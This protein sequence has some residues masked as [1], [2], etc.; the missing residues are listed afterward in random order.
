MLSKDR[1]LNSS[2]E[3]LKRA[4]LVGTLFAVASFVF[5]ILI[6]LAVFQYNHT[7]NLEDLRE[8]QFKELNLIK[9]EIQ[10]YYKY[11]LNSINVYS[12]IDATK[13]YLTQPTPKLESWLQNA[14]MQ[15]SETAEL[16]Q[17]MRVIDQHGME[18]IRVDNH[19][20]EGVRLI[21]HDELQDKSS[22]YYVK[23]TIENDTYQIY[24][25][26]FDLNI[27]NG[28]ID[29]PY[30][31]VIRLGNKI[32]DDNGSIL[33]VIIYNISGD[34]LFEV[35][36]G[37]KIHEKDNIYLLNADGY[38]LYHSDVDKTFTF[39]FEDRK[40]EGFFS[41]YPHI[42]E[43]IKSGKNES[44]SNEER[45][46]VLQMELFTKYTVNPKNNT[47]YLVMDTPNSLIDLIDK[48]LKFS[49]LF[50]TALLGPVFLI[51][52]WL[53]GYNLTKNKYYKDT[54]LDIASKDKLTGLYNRR[55]IYDRLEDII[56][57]SKRLNHQVTIVFVD[58]DRLK[59]V[60][61]NLG[62]DMGDAMIQSAADALTSSIR[63]AD[64]AARLGGDEFLLIL[65]DCDADNVK[66]II[67]RAAKH[68]EDKGKELADMDWS[69]SYG[70]A[71]Y[72]KEDT[73]DSLINR[74][75]A[76]MYKHKSS[77]R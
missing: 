14:M 50:S 12:K 35:I 13:N 18:R 25:S 52:S 7:H 32:L 49:L 65:I 43:D 19:L 47:Y 61:D 9:G 53:L 41:D 37:Q 77:R 56:E 70:L 17:Q 60:N 73:L 44:A 2:T 20:H 54:L 36:T 74:A 27:E 40:D 42:W 1:L 6:C 48:D 76:E 69:M 72:N 75:D 15:T 5:L 4:R 23:D 57:L 11:S 68:F 71:V 30:N 46:Y 63:S 59:Y 67:E 66:D 8:E 24:A 29:M 39:M 21:P 34:R 55:A 28:K 58:V 62:H 38:Y 64:L 33:G 16:F 51:S 22:R 45:M 26:P 31:P 10:S 3:A